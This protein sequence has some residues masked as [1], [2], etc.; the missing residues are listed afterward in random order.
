MHKTPTIDSARAKMGDSNWLI[1]SSYHVDRISLSP[2]EKTD[3][4]SDFGRPQNR[5]NKMNGLMT[6]QG[7]QCKQLF[8]E[9]GLRPTI[10]V[11]HGPHT[12]I[13]TL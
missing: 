3:H 4:E 7:G 5:T 6:C 13:H 11:A 9:R 2:Q 12:T 10:Y 8:R 1:H